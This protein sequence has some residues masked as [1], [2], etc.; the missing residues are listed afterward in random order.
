LSPVFL[1]A[2]KLGVNPLPFFRAVGHRTFFSPIVTDPFY[3]PVKA[4]EILSH[5]VSFRVYFDFDNPSPS[6]PLY[7]TFACPHFAP[8][9]L[10][11]AR[12][13][14]LLNF[15]LHRLR[16]LGVAPEYAFLLS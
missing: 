14:R 16:F 3:V 11:R 12:P 2:V 7:P 9:L 1:G 10:L 5:L 4:P 13:L 15:I 8:F 6:A